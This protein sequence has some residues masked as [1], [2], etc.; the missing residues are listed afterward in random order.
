MILDELTRDMINSARV[1]LL[2]DDDKQNI[3]LHF[4]SAEL[5][6]SRRAPSMPA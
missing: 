3:P 1:L 4:A 5:R 2:P 6:S